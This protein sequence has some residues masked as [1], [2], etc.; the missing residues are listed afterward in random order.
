MEGKKYNI[1]VLEASASG[2]EGIKINGGPFSL[3][4]VRAILED[5]GLASVALYPV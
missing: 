3:G 4:E 1:F 2:V 5:K